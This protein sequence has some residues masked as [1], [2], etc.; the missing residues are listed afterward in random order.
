[1]ASKGRPS[2]NGPNPE[3]GT[4]RV[5]RLVPDG[6]RGASGS[7]AGL[8]GLTRAD[9]GGLADVDES[10]RASAHFSSGSRFSRSNWLTRARNS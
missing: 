3:A 4:R 5:S 9:E 10:L 8:G 2:V 1:M 7:A 6:A